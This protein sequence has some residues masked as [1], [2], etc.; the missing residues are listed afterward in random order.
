MAD[1]GYLFATSTTAS[2]GAW[3]NL[4][5]IFATDGIEADCTISTKNT[6]SVRILNNFGFTSSVIPDDATVSQVF[7]RAVWRV[8]ST[9]GIARL[10]IAAHHSSAGLL[11]TRSQLGEPTTLTTDTYDITADRA[12]APADFRDG[13]LTVHVRP[14][15]GNDADNPGYKFDSVSLDAIYSV[16]APQAQR[17]LRS[18]CNLDGVGADGLLL[19]NT[20]E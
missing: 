9:S 20:L 13:T 15:N 16:P 8:S 18:A 17:V 6:S 19:G 10:G 7:L 5:N 3:A 1:T 12:W 14:S 2:T 11:S 4:G